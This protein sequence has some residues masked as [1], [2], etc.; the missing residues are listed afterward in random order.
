VAVL[1]DD[2]ELAMRN[3]LKLKNTLY[4]DDGGSMNADESHRIETSGK[5][6]K[7]GSVEQLFPCDM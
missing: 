7:C 3:R 2:L 5:L 4:I 6:V 1:Q